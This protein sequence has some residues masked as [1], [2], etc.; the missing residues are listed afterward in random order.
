M[1]MRDLGEKGYIRHLFTRCRHSPSFTASSDDAAFVDIPGMRSP[2]ALKIDRG[3]SSLSYQFG[4]SSRIVDGRL[5]A[6]ACCSDL[7]A[8]WSQPRALM[9]AITVPPETSI[10]DVDAAVD[11]F[12]EVCEENNV[13]FVGGDTKAGPWNLV[14]CGVGDIH[15]QPARRHAGVPGDI[16]VVCGEVGSFTAATLR[17]M[18]LAQSISL[19]DATAVLCHPVAR[20][21]EANWLRQRLLP[22]SA[23]D[24]SD[25]LYD[26]LLN[27]ASDGCGVTIDAQA[28]PFSDIARQVSDETSI[29]L[30]NFLYGGGDWNLV[31]AVPKDRFSSLDGMAPSDLGQV[32]AV[33]EVTAE[34][35]FMLSGAHGHSRRLIGLVSDHF[36]GRIEDPSHYFDRLRAHSGLTDFP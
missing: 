34:S 19:D 17:A 4:L 32:R 22:S 35:G 10:A 3:P 21:K 13:E 2:V 16:I 36:S 33:G 18:N 1:T 12:I 31:L 7:L 9:I 15:T 8:A 6:T 24:A 25:G 29:P 27:V 28:L 14:A 5:A 23:T 11:G 20:W 26:A 30:I